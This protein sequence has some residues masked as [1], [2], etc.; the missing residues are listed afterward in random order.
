MIKIPK[1]EII[2]TIIFV[3]AENIIKRLIKKSRKG[4]KSKMEAEENLMKY[5]IVEVY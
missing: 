1:S 5:I 2:T 4:G 3:I